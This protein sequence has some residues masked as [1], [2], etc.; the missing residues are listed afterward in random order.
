[1][2]TLKMA[3]VHKEQWK[4]SVIIVFTEQNVSTRIGISKQLSFHEYINI[5]HGVG[6]AC[7]PILFSKKIQK[8]FNTD[9]T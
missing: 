5:R 2:M 6:I 1:M 4:F 3:Q 9:N 8:A 7:L